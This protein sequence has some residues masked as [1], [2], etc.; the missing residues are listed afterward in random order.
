MALTE[1][2]RTLWDEWFDSQHDLM[3]CIEQAVNEQ[4][5]GKDKM[6]KAALYSAVIEACAESLRLNIDLSKALRQEQ[7]NGA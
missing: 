7:T 5:E 4:A 3:Q 6:F 2:A 1:S